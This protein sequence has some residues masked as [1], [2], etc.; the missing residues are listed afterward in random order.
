MFLAR[1]KSSTPPSDLAFKSGE[2]WSESFLPP[3]H[4][5]FHVLSGRTFSNFQLPTTLWNGITQGLYPKVAWIRRAKCALFP[6]RVDFF[7]ARQW[8]IC[9]VLWLPLSNLFKLTHALSLLYQN[10]ALFWRGY[11]QD[12]GSPIVILSS[13]FYTNKILVALFQ[14]GN[15]AQIWN[16]L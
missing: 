14:R 8:R 6:E 7:W 10:T 12:C 5:S 9:W 11:C 3:A 4:T 16:S 1:Q 2:L 13:I 15:D